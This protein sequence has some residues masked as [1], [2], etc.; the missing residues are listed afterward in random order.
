MVHAGDMGRL[1]WMKRSHAA[2][3]T[4]EVASWCFDETTRRRAGTA[5]N[6]CRHDACPTQAHGGIDRRQMTSASDQRPGASH[7]DSAS[8]DCHPQ[9]EWNNTD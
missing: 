6:S 1:V 8:T 2:I 3:P 5:T 9:R 4:T 7:R